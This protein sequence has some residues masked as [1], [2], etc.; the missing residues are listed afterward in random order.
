MIISGLQVVSVDLLGAGGM[1][2]KSIFV[3]RIPMNAIEINNG[4]ISYMPRYYLS[5]VYSDCIHAR[6]HAPKGDGN[7]SNVSKLN[8]G[9]HFG[10]DRISSFDTQEHIQTITLMFPNAMVYAII[11]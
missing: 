9:A 1:S 4:K 7:H 2:C 5:G 3:N 11:Y 8:I 10:T 6:Y